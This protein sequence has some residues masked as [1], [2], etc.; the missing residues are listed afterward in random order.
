MATL[1]LKTPLAK[2]IPVGMDIAYKDGWTL[3]EKAKIH[4]GGGTSL[5]I[6]SLVK[7]LD[8]ELCP[9][10]VY[11]WNCK[12]D[13]YPFTVGSEVSDTIAQQS[14]SIDPQGGSQEAIDSTI[15]D[16]AGLGYTEDGKFQ[17]RAYTEA[18]V[19]KMAWNNLQ[20]LCTHL[21]ITSGTK[22]VKE[23]A[24]VERSQELWGNL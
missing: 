15:N 24:V 9:E 23:K 6:V 20:K 8:K 4:M 13:T 14:I 10:D 22:E 11:F 5:N 3:D 16:K 21:G 19:R 17:K 18:E 1:K 2:L 12:P 7:E